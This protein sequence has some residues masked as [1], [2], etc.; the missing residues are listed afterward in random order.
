MI[1]YY[2]IDGRIGFKQTWDLINWDQ[3]KLIVSRI[4]A[5]IVKASKNGLKE[6]VR[7]L[8]RLLANSLASKLSAIKRV[9]S[10]RGKR[11]PGID[12]VLIDTPEKRWEILQK[13]NLR[14]YK[15]TPLKRIYIPK[16]NGKK[17]PLGIPIMHDRIEQALDLTGLAPIAEATAD[18]HSYGFRKSRSAWDAIG[19]VFNALRLKG[20]AKWVLEADIKGCFDYISHDWLIE[21]VPMNKAK[22]EQWLKCGYLEKHMYNPTNE[23]T[24]QGGII[25]PTLAN[26]ALDGIQKLLKGNF[27]QRADKIHFIRY[28][29]DFIV[30]GNSKELLQ[31]EVKPLIEKF[32]SVRGL[33]LSEEK[34]LVTHID[35][36]FNFLGFN[37]RKYNGK[38]LIKP[39]K[40]SIK[41]IKEKVRD[42]LNSNKAAKTEVVIDKLNAS[43]R[44][45]ANYY[46]HVVSKKVFCDLDHEFW[47]MTW[48][49]A[50]RRHPD[51]SRLWV[52]NKY[53][54]RIKGRDWRFMEKGNPKPLFLLGRI[55]IRRHVKINAEVN[56]YDPIWLDYLNKRS[57]RK[58]LPGV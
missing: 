27:N 3:Q 16:K 22:L 4:Q 58:Q 10:N 5:R 44:G 23:G 19:A 33:T 28:A 15:A 9:I 42:Y 50:K 40:S 56:P 55:P 35:D 48:K 41:R 30:T 34:T 12:N 14:G 52:K 6:K 45:W 39:A 43:I 21:N 57:I 54:Q 11:T 24:P 17:R 47:K 53:F 18:Y 7:S 1:S 20:S 26:I 29:D 32:L 2:D 36:G 49:W 51:K 31:N 8:Q 38:L 13:L 37:A 25:S 46:K